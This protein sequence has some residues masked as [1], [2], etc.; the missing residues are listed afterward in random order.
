MLFRSDF[1]LQEGDVIKI[2]YSQ[3]LISIKGSV[4]RQGKYEMKEKENIDNLLEYCGGLNDLAYRGG[5]TIISLTDTG[6]KVTNV[7]KSKFSNYQIKSGDEIFISSIQNTFSNRINISGSVLRP[8]DYE[9]TNKMTL[10][11]LIEKAGGL[12]PEE[13]GRAH[14]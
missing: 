6:R 11:S 14:V 10:K 13:I 7:D 12:L 2:P 3:T 8:G 5:A 9:L 1:L 4:K